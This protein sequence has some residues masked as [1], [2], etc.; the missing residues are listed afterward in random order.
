MDANAVVEV[1]LDLGCGENKKEGFTGVDI[2]SLP[3]VDITHDL[4][5]FPW[6]WDADTVDEIN[7]SYLYHFVPQ[8]LRII[9]IEEIYRVLK[10]GGKAHITVPHSA[11]W[12]GV[13]DAR[14]Q[15]PPLIEQSFVVFDKEWRTK[16][17]HDDDIKCD[18]S[19]I[20]AYLMSNPRWVSSNDETK[21]FA[22]THY[23]NVVDDLQV[24][25]IKK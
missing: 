24:T 25:L 22:L 8:P 15:W 14:T 5:K 6:P 21:G 2:R 23:R 10:K 7:C 9:F 13:F 1:K 16:T 17:K 12:R 18:F 3:C 20:A 19:V 4:F 11:S